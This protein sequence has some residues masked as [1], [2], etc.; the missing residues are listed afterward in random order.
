MTCIAFPGQD[1]YLGPVAKSTAR[2]A[3]MCR[4]A[5]GLGQRVGAIPHL[6]LV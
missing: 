5:I 3:D 2:D 1:T 6:V 4:L